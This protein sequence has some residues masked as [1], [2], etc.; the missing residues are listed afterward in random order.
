M[1]WISIRYSNNILL[2]VKHVDLFVF[3]QSRH[4]MI[5][6]VD[7]RPVSLTQK[8]CLA[9][10]H[11]SQS[12]DGKYLLLDAPDMPTLRVPLHEPM[13]GDVINTR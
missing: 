7:N 5:V 12:E 6:D 2:L 8:S 10:I 1:T 11:T 13:T 4:F 3:P 9:L